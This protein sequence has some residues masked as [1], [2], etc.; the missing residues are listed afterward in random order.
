MRSRTIRILWLLLAL[1]AVVFGVL[2]VSSAPITAE[3]LGVI[4]WVFPVVGFILVVTLLDLFAP[5]RLD[6]L[7][8]W[9][10]WGRS[11]S[12]SYWFVVV[13]YGVYLSGHWV[14]HEQPTYG[15]FL[16]PIELCFLCCFSWGL[17]FLLFFDLDTERARAFGRGVAQSK[18][19][20]LMVMLTTAVLIFAGAEAYLRIFYITTDAY[21]FTA[22]NYHWYK[23]F[24]WGHENSLGYRDYEPKGDDGNTPLKTVAVVGDSFAAGHGIDDIDET[25]PQ[26]LEQ[27]LGSGWDV[28]L[29]AQS[30]WDS[31]V[32]T[33]WLNSYSQNVKHNPQVVVL[34]YYLNDIDYLLTDTANNPDAVFTFP[35]NPTL[36]WFVLNFFVP[37]YIYYNMLQF[38]SPVKN[39][40]FTDR[41]IR[42][43][44]DDALWGQQEGNL[45]LLV[46]WVDAHEAKLVVLLWPQ[47]AAIPQS[48]PALDRVRQ[49]FEGQGAVIVDMSD[50]LK[51]KSTPELILNRFDSHPSRLSNAIA[52]E[53]LYQAITAQ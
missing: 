42:A 53:A 35:Q 7:R 29:V 47:L 40:N 20:G 11:R 14:W 22:M 6:G 2:S 39:T 27:K 10:G 43:H 45:Q 4:G 18:L 44:L 25:F 15:R 33:A 13:F 1:G 23:N 31:D 50:W 9:F 32:E 38:T 28:N 49:F 16:T 52:A 30:G 3:T 17:L 19:S 5:R 36:G 34:S 26:L 21:G 46:D 37:N 48:K 41:L 12:I 8:R 51:D 24:Y